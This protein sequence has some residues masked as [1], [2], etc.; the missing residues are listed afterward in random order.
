MLTLAE[1]KE[2]I[3]NQYDPDLLLEALQISAEDLLDRFEDRFILKID[4]L[5]EDYDDEASV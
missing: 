5:L 4:D 3:L 2:R 1:K